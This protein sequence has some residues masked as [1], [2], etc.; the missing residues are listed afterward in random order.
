MRNI[1]PN[2]VELNHTLMKMLNDEE[3]INN[4]GSYFLN[5]KL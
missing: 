4:D 2:Y 5:I 3:I 1:D